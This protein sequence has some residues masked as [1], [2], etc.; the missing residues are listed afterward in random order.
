MWFIG[1]EVEQETSASPPKKNP[2]SAPGCWLTYGM[3]PQSTLY[4]AGQ[5]LVVT[6]LTNNMEREQKIDEKKKSER[7]KKETVMGSLIG[8]F[9]AFNV[10]LIIDSSFLF[11]QRI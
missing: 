7:E 10:S 1:V 2:G 4:V 3:T 8:W 5:C 11:S 9:A 6:L